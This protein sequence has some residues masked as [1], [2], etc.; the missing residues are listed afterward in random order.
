MTMYSRA[1]LDLSLIEH[2]TPSPKE[3][4]SLLLRR[5]RLVKMVLILGQSLS[6]SYIVHHGARL[7]VDRQRKV[8]RRSG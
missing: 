4:V 6:W 8:A 5:S 2:G 7:E 3:T 1:H